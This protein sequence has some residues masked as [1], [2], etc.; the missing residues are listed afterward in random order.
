MVERHQTVQG[1]AAC[2]WGAAPAFQAD[3]QVK[4]GRCS[5]SS[6]MLIRRLVCTHPE[7]TCMAFRLKHW[8]FTALEVEETGSASLGM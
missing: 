6:A 7:I 8:P 3:M 5:S 4:G 2:Q 1:N